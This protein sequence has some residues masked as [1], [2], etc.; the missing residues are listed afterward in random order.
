MALTAYLTGTIKQP[1]LRLQFGWGARM[2]KGGDAQQ[3]VKA[4]PGRRFDKEEKCWFITGTGNNPD[5]VLAAA[6]IEVDYS[7]AK[8]DLAGLDSLAPL[9]KPLVIRSKIFP[10][11]AMVRPRFAGY[12]PVVERLGP[13][14]VWDKTKQWFTV[15]ITD[16]VDPDTRTAKRGFTIDDETVEAALA[17]L[18]PDELPEDVEAAARELA[19]STGTD[20]V[21]MDQLDART[22]ELIDI[23]AS[24]TGRLPD[25]FG[26]DLF[27]FQVAGAYAAAA[28]RSYLVDA[29]GLGKTRQ[30]LAAAAID[31]VE[32]LLIICPP[33]VLTNFACEADRALGPGLGPREAE[34]AKPSVKL[35][36]AK[37]RRPAKPKK[38]AKKAEFH[39][40]IVVIR[41]GRKIPDLPER[42]VVVVAD[43]L[44]AAAKRVDLLRDVVEWAPNGLLVDESHRLRTWTSARGTVVRNIASIVSGL[45]LPMTG[46]PLLANP[47][48]LTNQLA[49]AGHLD[50][51][52]GGASKFIETYATKDRFGGWLT[53]KKMLPQLRDILHQDVWVRRNK[54]DVLTQLPAKWRTVTYVDVDNKLFEEAHT[55][56][57]EK[58]A[59]WVDEVSPD[60]SP[61]PEHVIAD[62]AKTNIGLSSPLR[63][64]AG[65]SKIP[66]AIDYVTNWL[67]SST[68]TRADGTADY[69]RPLVVWAHHQPVIEGLRDAI[70]AEGVKGV[71]VITGTTT[72][73]KRTELADKFQAGE[74]GVLF[75]SII[76]AGF[77]ITLTR[78][79]DALF[80]EPDWTPAHISQAEDRI[81]RIGQSEPCMITTML[82][83]GTLDTSVRAVLKNK[84]KTL[85]VVM[86][87]ADNNV[88]EI[89]AMIN[90]EGV[91][92]EYTE[93]EEEL[94]KVVK[95]EA[96]IIARIVVDILDQRGMVEAA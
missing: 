71:G 44:L 72:S 68:E 95:S 16:L 65:L 46:T 84:G 26:L 56:L 34:P 66:A 78:S 15:R 92:E 30:A 29:P 91:Y 22:L 21:N 73:L 39:Q 80:V 63:V 67:E 89:T 27:P 52:F 17:L 59:E 94:A 43:S 58:I 54:K 2:P 14:A 76:A 62:Y 90:D 82:A 19:L 77:G 3:W 88:T 1:E 35:S 40:N 18:E 75:C 28:G 55:K 8:G 37:K 45:R 32:R 42:G 96:D 64:A 5:K 57:Y 51:V 11:I 47:V 12:E 93:E 60:G 83:P 50:P 61:I 25:W 23:V 87:G 85:N 13:G 31:G 41:P 10:Q 20:G 33:L 79:S 49:I 36:H 70:I 7:E 86:P 69:T 38:P 6:G 4:L 9:W 74:I 48:E 81:H 53:K 24:Y